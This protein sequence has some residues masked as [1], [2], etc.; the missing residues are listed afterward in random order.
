MAT[1]AKKLVRLHGPW[2]GINENLGSQEPGDL[3]AAW[4]VEIEGDLI[5][6]RRGRRLIS[7]AAM[8]S[9]PLKFFVCTGDVEDKGSSSYRRDD[10]T[11]DVID[12]SYAT[13]ALIENIGGG[14]GHPSATVSTSEQCAFE[15]SLSLPS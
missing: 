3:E 5:R 11:Q 8:Y 6:S 4:N 13:Y 7:P 14:G 9:R 10:V 15:I 1:G 2:K 12:G